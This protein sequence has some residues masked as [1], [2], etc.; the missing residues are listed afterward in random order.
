MENSMKVP[1]K[2]K[3]RDFPGGQRLCAPTA[4]G[5]GSI[6][7]QGTRIPHAVWCSQKGKKKGKNKLKLELSY[8][9]TVPLL[10]IHQELK[11][12]S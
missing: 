4:G 7:G 12:G 6:P 2:I 5:V 9:P 1:Q 8:D 10:G 3:T 11:A